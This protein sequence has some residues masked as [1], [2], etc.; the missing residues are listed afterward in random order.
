MTMFLSSS[1]QDDRV[2]VGHYRDNSLQ[3]QIIHVLQIDIVLN[4]LEQSDL[5]LFILHCACVDM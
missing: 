5:D 1:G 2:D 3:I 4:T